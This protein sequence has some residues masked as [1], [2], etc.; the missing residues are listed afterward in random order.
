M[1]CDVDDRHHHLSVFACHNKCKVSLV[2]LDIDLKGRAKSHDFHIV[3]VG[4]PTSHFSQ[5]TLKSS[6]DFRCGR[7]CIAERSRKAS[8][9]LPFGVSSGST[10]RVYFNELLVVGSVFPHMPNHT[11]TQLSML[12]LV[13]VELIGKGVEEA[14]PYSSEKRLILENSSLKVGGRWGTLRGGGGTDHSQRCL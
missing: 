6:V 9:I 8:G 10:A 5:M 13:S 14:I 2:D 4:T 12:G 7:A 1:I 11:R 3:S